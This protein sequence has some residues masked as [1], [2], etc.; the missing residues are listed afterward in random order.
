MENSVFQYD[1][2]R[3]VGLLNH[4]VHPSEEVS[5]PSQLKGRDN[6]LE[7]LRDAFETRGMNAFV[8]GQR[9]VGKTSLVHTACAKYS[10]TVRLAAAISCDKSSSHI[11]LLNDIYRRVISEG[12]IRLKD[13]VVKAKLSAFGVSFEGNTPTIREAIDVR[14]VN[15]A[16]DLLQ[17]ILPDDHEHQREWVVIVDE[18]DLLENKD[19]IHFFTALAKQISVDKVPVKFVFC[20]VASNL[21]D[22]IGSHE[23]VERY[24]KAVELKPLLNGFIMEIAHYISE[25]FSISLLKGQL[26]RIA[27]ISCGYPHF[28]HLIMR[29]VL[30][31]CYK[32]QISDEKINPDLFKCAVQNAAKGAATRLQVAYDDA[33]KK[34]TDNYI[35]VL[36][37]AADGQHLEK[38]FKRINDDYLKIMGSRANRDPVSNEKNLRNYLN[39][40][41]KPSYG[42]VLVRGKVGWYKFNDPMFRSYVRMV[43]HGEGVDLGE[44][45][46]RR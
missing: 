6:A 9:G 36:W 24:I 20:G 16:S 40:L 28:V 45:S 26:T 8:W 43:A 37:A 23:S 46:F 15:H 44:E 14:S 29:E 4:Y 13:P 7:Q 21:N 17:T 5:D 11:E 32:R 35:E 25:N 22:L 18:F 27:Q 31:E 3:F 33:T 1:R 2:Q 39:N 34:G 19:T 10:D 41:T 12:K 30:S 42:S 38:Q